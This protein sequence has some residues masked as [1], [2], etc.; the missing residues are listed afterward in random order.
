LNKSKRPNRN[1]A[2]NLDFA[3]LIVGQPSDD[4][5]VFFVQL[6][7]PPRKLST[8]HAIAAKS[9]KAPTVNICYPPPAIS[10]RLLD[11]IVEI[12]IRNKDLG[13]LLD[14]FSD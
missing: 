13:K 10:W 8:R 1:R 5:P 7:N 9:K 3:V 12:P 6:F 2:R 4:Q 14:F 11:L